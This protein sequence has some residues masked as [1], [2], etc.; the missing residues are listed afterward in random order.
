[1]HKTKIVALNDFGQSAWL[2]NISRSLITSG[3]L[4]EM[5]AL[6]LRGMTSNP[7]IFDK[8][9][10]NSSD[11]DEQV[12]AFCNTGKSTFEIY[13]ELTVKDI[14]DAA[15]LFAPVYEQ[16]KRLDGYVSL[17]INPQLSA[18]V[19]ET[20]EEGMRLFKKVNRPNVMFKVP[21]TDA[22]FEA[23]EE[24]LAEGININVT[25]IFSLSQYVRTTHA[26]IKGVSRLLEK[27]GDLSTVASVASVFVSRIDTLID[28]T[29]DARLGQETDA[30][31]KR[32]LQS[33]KGKAAAAN[34]QRIYEKYRDIFSSNDF[35]KLTARGARPQRVLWG[36]TS[37]KNPGYSDIKYVT[38]LIAKDTVNT[39][40]DTTFEAFLDHGNVADAFIRDRAEAQAILDALE[41]YGI[42]IDTVCSQLLTDGVA[43]FEK[44]FNSLLHS[45]ENKTKKLHVK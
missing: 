23:I 18:K 6:G 24:L 5:I 7:T 16:T 2:D 26:F 8:S 1:M 4:K 31:A 3:K 30:S 27:T 43:A 28:T 38:E 44:S 39:M 22:G 32:T 37:T 9:I 35:Q 34:S 13:D 36:S 17:E 12:A 10:S 21:S 29:I 14:H 41:G 45:I 25:L 20:I 33:L 11:Y 19:D 40:P 42:D 15:D